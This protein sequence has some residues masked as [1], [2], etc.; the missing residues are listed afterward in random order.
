VVGILTRLAVI[1]LLLSVVTRNPFV[2]LAFTLLVMVALV[3]NL[4]DRYALAGV[5]YARRLGTERLFVGETMKLSSSSAANAS[6]EALLNLNREGSALNVNTGMPGVSAFHDTRI[7]GKV[8]L[9]TTVL[10]RLSV[11][12]GFTLNR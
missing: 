11:A 12:F 3:S 4:W 2:F 6:V 1:L 8:G 10:S 9:T 5:T 7:V